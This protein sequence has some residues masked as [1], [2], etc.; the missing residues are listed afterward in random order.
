MRSWTLDGGG[1]GTRGPAPSE[2]AAAARMEITTRL[3]GITR[4][5]VIVAST[6]ERAFGSTQCRQVSRG[7]INTRLTVAAP[8]YGERRSA[9]TWNANKM[10]PMA[11][12]IPL[13][14]AVP[15]T[16][17]SVVIDCPWIM[18]IDA[19]AQIA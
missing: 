8:T 12:R 7:L 9:R 4:R 16:T 14:S 5:P 10:I 1:G 3:S 13:T 15:V 2:Q 18:M 19:A 11:K 17:R 6:R